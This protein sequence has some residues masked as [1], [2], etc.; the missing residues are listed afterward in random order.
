MLKGSM[1]KLNGAINRLFLGHT[2][3]YARVYNPVS[4]QKLL[5]Q[6]NINEVKL[7]YN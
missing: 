1:P 7:A 5:G 2:N 4:E 3:Q 6:A